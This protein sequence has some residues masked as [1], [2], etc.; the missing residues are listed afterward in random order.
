M[1]A[2]VTSSH[3]ISTL[4]ALACFIG[5][6]SG[7]A[8]ATAAP[9]PAPASVNTAA[10]VTKAS[11]GQS[12]L[13]VGFD[14]AG[15]LRA[16]LCTK[17]P[18][19]TQ[20]GKAVET[21]AEARQNV[22]NARLRAV[23]IGNDRTAIVVTIP[24]PQAR[25]WE[26]VIVAPIGGREPKVVWSGLTGYVEGVEGERSG[27]MVFVDNGVYVGEQ[28]ED[29][30]LCGRP[31]IL[32]PKVLNPT[33]LE[34]HSAKV[35]R[36]TEAE[37]SRAV[38]LVAK[39]NDAP[40]PSHSMLTPLWA[41]SAS[42]TE[43]PGALADGNVET[44]WA[45]NR[46]GVGRGEFA[47]LLAPPELSLTGFAVVVRPPT[48]QLPNAV[49]PKEFWLATDT[50]VYRVTMPEDAWKNPGARYEVTLDKPVKT[51][52]IAVVL[53]DAY[54]DKDDARV[55]IAE[56]AAHTALETAALPDLV[57]ALKG[58]GEKAE[59]AAATLRSAGP[60]A[61][62]AVAK[63]FGDLDEPGQ[64]VA[65]DVM[66][67]APCEASLPV[68]IQA[69][70]GP[71]PPHRTAA[72]DR[73]RAC[74]DRGAAALEAALASGNEASRTAI[75]NEFAVAAPGPAVRV[76]LA[77]LTRADQNMR[78]AY[79]VALAYASQRPEAVE[80]IRHALADP[81]LKEVALIDLLRALGPR[82][83][84][85]RAAHQAFARLATP[86]ASF[87][88]RY[89]M[90]GVAAE[91]A[92]AGDATAASFLRE[93]LVR[94][95]S[96][97]VRA[98]AASVVKNPA[99]YRD[100]LLYAVQDSGVRVREAAVQSLAAGQAQFAQ[101]AIVGRLKSDQWPRV[102]AAAAQALAKLAPAPTVDQAL[103]ESAQEDPS[104]HVR[105]PALLALGERRALGQA[106]MVRQQLSDSDEDPTVRSA[107]ALALGMMCHADSVDALT[108]YALKLGDPNADEAAREIARGALTA[109][110]FMQPKDLAKRLA[111]LQSKG[112]PSV[113][114]EAARAAL[115]ARGRCGTGSTRSAMR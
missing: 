37:R 109:L 112:I 15:V 50:S 11:G 79:R 41:T 72:H 14:T 59:A 5:I 54:G 71:F 95:K 67:H 108:K 97:H 102:R 8:S 114:R 111:P 18:C 63:A 105:R 47:V 104:P 4:C 19:T 68:Y 70:I 35:Q 28:R 57:K 27:P 96:P 7:G 9:G 110:S 85:Y 53:E 36:L 60:D 103:A 30:T 80:P 26:A 24:L 23:R 55:A 107:A 32:A 48:R 49:A 100:E 88:V 10:A 90:L 106:N 92:A 2:V 69:L 74:G 81:T 113:Y 1:P 43:L 12:S 94:D 17:E 75:A 98:H 46:T 44:A 77:R 84:D 6:A 99:Q 56:L 93:S 82:I 78:R 66:D 3:R 39:R 58:G 51:G 52:C 31:A 21:P 22:K 83:K 16:A 38:Q 87:R 65:M 34:L 73:I 64:R 115:S 91:L 20:G 62:A 101:S 40:M 33:T 29:R 25:S 13:A 61:F 89:L 42:G 45:E 86:N 76:F